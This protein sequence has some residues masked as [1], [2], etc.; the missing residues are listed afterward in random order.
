[1]SNLFK[2]NNRFSSLIDESIDN[3]DKYRNKTFDKNVKNTRDDRSY[4]FNSAR[5]IER[6][7]HLDMLE[8]EKK[9]L[10]IKE[11][12]KVENFPQ[13]ISCENNMSN[14]F[15]DNS[16]NSN[17]SN[18]TQNTNNQTFLEKLKLE[19]Q[20]QETKNDLEDKVDPGW[21]L[22]KKSKDSNK[23]V[24]KYGMKTIVEENTTNNVFN[25]LVEI[26]ENFKQKYIDLWGEEEY[27]NKFLFPNYDY[28]YFDRLDELYEKE[29]D[30]LHK[31]EL[32]REI[33]QE[34]TN[35]GYSDYY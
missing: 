19:K 3:K 13:L 8:K 5:N 10:A 9:Q 18:N 14:K 30:L 1:M 29:M 31:E 11:S 22:L 33:L 17:N 27:E 21:V 16:N 34:Y 12:L 24:I 32:E 4:N 25:T 15:T 23:I 20:L 26:N 6:K 35:N 2:N 28:E 7:L